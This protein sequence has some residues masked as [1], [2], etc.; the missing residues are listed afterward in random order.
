MRAVK[1]VL[2]RA[3]TPRGFKCHR[4]VGLNLGDGWLP[5]RSVRW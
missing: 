1:L 2:I 4:G 3:Q 5:L